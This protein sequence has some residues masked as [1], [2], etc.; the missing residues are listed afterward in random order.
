M[1]NNVSR[2][3]EGHS[4]PVVNVPNALTVLRLVLVPIFVWLMVADFSSARWW[5]LAVFC[6]AAA[7]D[8]LDGH[9]A[10]KYNLITDFGKVADPIADKA[11]T[12]GAFIMLSWIGDLPWWFTIIVAVRELGITWLR[13]VLLKRGIVVAANKGGKLKTVLQMLL[14]VLMLLPW[15][16]FVGNPADS[17]LPLWIYVMWFIVGG[18]ALVVTVWSGLVY[19]IGGWKLSKQGSQ[20]VHSADD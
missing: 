4:V 1:D 3:D 5:A 19:I 9:I 7:T 6:V 13:A 17:A 8:Q 20:D 16:Q 10:R 11:L 15:A 12:L 18:A 14:I 2:L